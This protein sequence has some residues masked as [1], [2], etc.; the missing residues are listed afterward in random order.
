MLVDVI[1]AEATATVFAVVMLAAIV[2]VLRNAITLEV[3]VVASLQIIDKL[4]ITAPSLAEQST[5]K[6]HPADAGV[7]RLVAVLKAAVAPSVANECN[8]LSTKSGILF[9]LLV[10]I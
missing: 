8:G 2:A 3:V 7:F 9:E 6:T 1:P 10:A 4:S 5:S